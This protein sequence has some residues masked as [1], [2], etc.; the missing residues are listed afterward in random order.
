VA[1]IA[2]NVFVRFRNLPSNAGTPAHVAMNA[3]VGVNWKSLVWDEVNAICS[4][5]SG[6]VVCR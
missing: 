1:R 4:K 2:W 3:R 6:S 5:M